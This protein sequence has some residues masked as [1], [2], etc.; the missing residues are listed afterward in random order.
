MVCVLQASQCFLF[1]DLNQ[2]MKICFDDTKERNVSD[3]Q[4]EKWVRQ[5]HNSL[6]LLCYA[7]VCKACIGCV[8]MAQLTELKIKLEVIMRRESYQRIEQSRKM[9]YTLMFGAMVLS[10]PIVIVP[11]VMASKAWDYL[12]TLFDNFFKFDPTQYNEMVENAMQ[13]YGTVSGIFFMGISVAMAFMFWKIMRLIDDEG[14][15]SETMRDQKSGLIIMMIFVFLSYF[16]ASLVNF[17][18]GNYRQFMSLYTRW[19]LYPFAAILLEIPNMMVVYVIH[20]RSYQTP[21][22]SLPQD[23]RDKSNDMESDMMSSNWSDSI[24]SGD[25]K[26][27]SNRFSYG[28]KTSQSGFM[29]IYAE[30][31]SNFMTEFN[32]TSDGVA[33]DNQQL[34]SVIDTATE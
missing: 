34:P 19:L 15:L 17:G 3:A 33:S 20:W 28:G 6:I 12:Q 10:L 7:M 27:L 16:C 21:L 26:I 8:Q 2:H 25:Q 24:Q 5:F 18:Y 14:K 22:V 23:R 1:F 32:L 31:H 30:E 13:A 9:T 4:T 11:Q 29:Q